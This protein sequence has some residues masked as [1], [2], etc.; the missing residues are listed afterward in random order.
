MSDSASISKWLDA[1]RA[2]GEPRVL[3]VPIRV[4]LGESVEAAKFVDA[5]WEPTAERPGLSSAGPKLPR[6]IAEEILSLRDAAQDAET[7][8]LKIV[9]PKVDTDALKDRGTQ[10]LVDITA[11]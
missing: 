3:S 8:Y 2:V 10:L 7:E 4:L 11:A 5:Y 6:T 1:A 9:D